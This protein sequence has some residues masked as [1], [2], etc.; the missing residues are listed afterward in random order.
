MAVVAEH[1]RFAPH[2]ETRAIHGGFQTWGL[3]VQVLLR[4]SVHP[5]IGQ[6]NF[7][8]C[9]EGRREPTQLSMLDLHSIVRFTTSQP[10]TWAGSEPHAPLR[11]KGA[12][13]EETKI[14]DA[15]RLIEFD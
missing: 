5:G 8:D 12:S 13:L 15:S 4:W 7:E 9:G 6:I 2:R 11:L 3:V 14:V 10:R 1:V